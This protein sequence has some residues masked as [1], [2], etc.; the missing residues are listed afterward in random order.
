[1]DDYLPVKSRLPELEEEHGLEPHQ[2]YEDE[3]VD[4]PKSQYSAFRTGRKKMGARSMK[5]LAEF[6]GVPMDD[7]YTWRKI[8]RT[9]GAKKN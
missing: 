3:K 8:K 7:L 5:R 2:V 6:F 1:M 9:R 4:M